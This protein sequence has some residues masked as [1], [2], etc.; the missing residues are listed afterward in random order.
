MINNF[1]NNSSENGDSR[2]Q[3]RCSSKMTF[4]K[5]KAMQGPSQPLRE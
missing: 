5:E 1:S 3:G 4:Q 2:F